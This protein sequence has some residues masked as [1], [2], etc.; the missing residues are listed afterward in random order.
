M[1]EIQLTGG[2]SGVVSGTFI[3]ATKGDLTS[4]TVKVKLVP[5]TDPKPALTDSD[6]LTP[7]ID[8]NV[9]GRIVFHITINDTTAIGEHRVYGA[10]TLSGVTE[11]VA[12]DDFVRTV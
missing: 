6:W 1:R 4:A 9:G 5:R 2:Y 10:I 12:A 3:D 8:S 11:L 7:V